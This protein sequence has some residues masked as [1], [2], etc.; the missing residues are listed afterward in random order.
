MHASLGDKY[1]LVLDRYYSRDSARIGRIHHQT[2]HITTG[3]HQGSLAP[4]LSRWILL[5]RH[6]DAY[7]TLR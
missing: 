4:P 6:V 3:A 1:T 2:D 5:R 7:C